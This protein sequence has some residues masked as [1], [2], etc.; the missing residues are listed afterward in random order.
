MRSLIVLAHG[1]RT[2][3]ANAEVRRLVDGLR[4][5]LEDDT[6]GRVAVAFLDMAAP[7]L[8]A[9]VRHEVSAGAAEIV[10]MPLFLASGRHVTEHVPRLVNAER[11]RHAGVRFEVLPHVGGLAGYTGFVAGAIRREITP[12]ALAHGSSDPSPPDDEN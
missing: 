8:E 7:T 9:C 11:A 10:V 5:E 12:P 4:A 1:S 2:D 6:I 3:A